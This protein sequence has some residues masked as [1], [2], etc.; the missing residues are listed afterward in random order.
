MKARVDRVMLIDD[1]E[2]DNYVHARILRRSG[3][4]GEVL[5]YQSAQ[6]ALDYIIS[7]GEQKLERIDMIFLDINMPGMS[8]WE[9]LDAYQELPQ[10]LQSGIVVCM[11]TT[12]FA[13]E[14]Q[15]KASG[16]KS[17]AGY[18]HKPL[19]NDTFSELLDQHFPEAE[20]GGAS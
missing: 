19:S 14:D 12:S 9:F 10:H 18:T 5:I 7:I 8:G 4:V 17:L 20:T 15:D 16:Y 3:L 1:S 6:V 2:A 11:L 13:R